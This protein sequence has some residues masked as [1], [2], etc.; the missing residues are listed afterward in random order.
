MSEEEAD[1]IRRRQL[2]L[3]GHGCP[4]PVDARPRVVLRIGCARGE[5]GT[6]RFVRTPVCELLG[7]EQPIVQ[8]PIGSAACP[9]PR[10]RG[11]RRGALGMLGL[12]WVADVAG[13]IVETAALTDR[14]FGG[15]FVLASDQHSRLTESLDAGLR[16]SRSP[17]ADPPPTL[18]VCTRPEVSCC[19][20]WGV[21]RRRDAQSAVIV[22]H[23]W[24][25]GGHVRGSVATLP[26]VPA[27]V[28]AVA[29]VPVIAAGG[30]GERQGSRARFLLATR[31][32]AARGLPASAHSRGR[33]RSGVVPRPV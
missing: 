4:I 19:T 17:G 7:F 26:L 14:S 18:T 33:D 15:N 12:T 29:P 30:I 10:G 11:F 24:E 25:A 28:D 1:S 2:R 22:A 27:V 16:M 21:P 5:C 3:Q 13:V 23:R 9:A 31:G 32:A 6:F 20:R 8:A